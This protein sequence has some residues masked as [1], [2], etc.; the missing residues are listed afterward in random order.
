M[1]GLREA[2]L[3]TIG[4]ERLSV[5]D[6]VKKSALHHLHTYGEEARRERQRQQELVVVRSGRHLSLAFCP[7]IMVRK[8]TRVVAGSAAELRCH[9][10]GL[11]SCRVEE[12]SGG[13]RST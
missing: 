4:L 6:A 2:H 1:A 12:K 8:P 11:G 9:Y 5:E 7:P 13:H 10:G 3:L